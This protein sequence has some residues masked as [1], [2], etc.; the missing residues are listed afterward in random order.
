M[1]L[2]IVPLLVGLLATSGFPLAPGLA[3][4]AAVGGAVAD[5]LGARGPDLFA[6]FS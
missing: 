4:P 6:G 2:A 5:S 1:P 3:P